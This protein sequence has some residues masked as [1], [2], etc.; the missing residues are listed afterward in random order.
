MA[1][2]EIDFID[3]NT[4]LN[5]YFAVS[6]RSS[7]YR[8]RLAMEMWHTL[9]AEEK[10]LLQRTANKLAGRDLK[11]GAAHTQSILLLHYVATHDATDNLPADTYHISQK[12]IDK[13]FI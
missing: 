1:S 11:L 9:T 6:T 12:S 5:R 4:T 13:T 7:L 2:R 8:Q 3:G 10:L